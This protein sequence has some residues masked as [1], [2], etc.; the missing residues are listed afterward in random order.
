MEWSDQ[1]QVQPS[2]IWRAQKNTAIH[3]ARI[4]LAN[5]TLSNTNADIPTHESISFQDFD[6]LYTE[7]SQNHPTEEHASSFFEKVVF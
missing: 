4:L 1:N 2:K 5:L 7:I 3:I 6:E